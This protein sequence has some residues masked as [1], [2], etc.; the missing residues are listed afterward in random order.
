MTIITATTKSTST[1][2]NRLS[3]AHRPRR[4]AG[5][6]VRAAG[7]PAGWA[8][9][10]S[11]R[12]SSALQSDPPLARGAALEFH[13]RATLPQRGP[14]RA[15]LSRGRSPQQAWTILRAWNGQPTSSPRRRARLPRRRGVPHLL[16]PF[17]ASIVLALIFTAGRARR[18]AHARRS[19]RRVPRGRRRADRPHRRERAHARAPVV[20]AARQPRRR[21]G[22]ARARR[23]LAGYEFTVAA[24]GVVVVASFATVAFDHWKRAVAAGF[25]VAAG[26]VLVLLELP[27]G[28]VAGGAR[29]RGCRSRW[30]GSWPSSSASTA[31]ASSGP[32]AGPRSLRPTARPAPARP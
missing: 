15:H 8:V 21:R 23:P 6:L 18:A 29:R 3:A 32:S 26:V 14:R 22:P 2:R 13:G 28:P 27:V 20:V 1:S 11:S 12:C 7:R 19:P 25:V 30:S 16:E 5:T 17:P 10:R 9:Y 4:G 24:V 31:A